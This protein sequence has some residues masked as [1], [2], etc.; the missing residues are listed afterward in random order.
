MGGPSPTAAPSPLSLGLKAI[1]LSLGRGGTAQRWVR[2]R[3]RTWCICKEEARFLYE[4]S[5][6]LELVLPSS[7]RCRL[8]FSPRA[9]RM[10]EPLL[11]R[12][13]ACLNAIASADWQIFFLTF[14]SDLIG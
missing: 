14:D 4:N 10:S 7:A 8:K 1:T 12:V 13:P 6:L 2:V 3:N 9:T 5:Q 11:D